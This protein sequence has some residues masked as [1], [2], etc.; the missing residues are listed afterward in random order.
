MQ[1]RIYIHSHILNKGSIT[2]NT[3]QIEDNRLE[4]EVKTWDSREQLTV[5]ELS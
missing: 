4:L 1:N 2:S 3:S 5:N